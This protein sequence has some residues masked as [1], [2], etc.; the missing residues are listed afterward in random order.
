M[1]IL[2]C[3]CYT[4][5]IFICNDFCNLCPPFYT[6]LVSIPMVMYNSNIKYL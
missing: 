6:L 3:A 1:F 5:D 2:I 4:K